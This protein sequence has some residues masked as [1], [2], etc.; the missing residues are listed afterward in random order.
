MEIIKLVQQGIA[1]MRTRYRFRVSFQ[2]FLACALFS[3]HALTSA[4][5]SASP[6]AVIETAIRHQSLGLAY[7]EESQPSKAISEFEAL[8]EIIPQEPI[9][10]GNLAVAYLRLQKSDEA[11][12]WVT[13]GLEVAPMD[14]QLRF[15]LAEVYQWQGKTE[16]MVAENSGSCKT[17]TG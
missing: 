8:V 1:A 12:T 7:L 4:A 11:E 2:I 15:I 3:F 17:R 9:G 6:S 13:R 10:Y 5:Q 16:E 14:S